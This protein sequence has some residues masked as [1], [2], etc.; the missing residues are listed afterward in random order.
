MS[1]SESWI[2]NTT[3]ADELIAFASGEAFRNPIHHIGLVWDFWDTVEISEKHV[4]EEA[5]KWLHWGWSTL[6]IPV[7]KR[8]WRIYYHE[9][10]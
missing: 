5:S 3:V 1:T 10:A 9:S 6:F 7:G 4:P 8:T 2:F